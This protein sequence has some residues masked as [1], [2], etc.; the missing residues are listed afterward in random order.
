VKILCVIPSRLASTRLPRKPL[1][2]IQGKPMIQWVYERAAQCTI[3][4]EVI[5]ATDSEEIAEV[6]SNAGGKFMMTDPALKTGSD[7]VAA[8]ATH[9]PEMEVIINLQG[10]E[11]F[12][13]PIMLEQ[14]VTP[15]L[16]GEFVE[17]TTLAYPMTT[18]EEMVS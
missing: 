17:M 11:P 13:Q 6:V 3:L 4:S 7:R 9:Y 5:V 8:V 16:Q 18:Q 2:N 10:D 1:I 15:Y 12:I 14:L